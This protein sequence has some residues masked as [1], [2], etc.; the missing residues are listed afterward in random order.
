MEYRVHHRG[1]RADDA[2]L[3]HALDPERRHVGIVLVD[4]DDFDLV[5]VQGAKRRAGRP[6]QIG[7]VAVADDFPPPGKALA[8]ASSMPVLRPFAISLDAA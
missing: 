7:P 8:A 1:R 5:I 2:D 6:G 4:E 3:A